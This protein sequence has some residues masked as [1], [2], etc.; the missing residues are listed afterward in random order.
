MEKTTASFIAYLN[1][2]TKVNHEFFYD[3]TDAEN[4]LREGFGLMKNGLISFFR[5]MLLLW[6]GLGLIRH[7][8]I[9]DRNPGVPGVMYKV[10]P[11]TEEKRKSLKNARELWIATVDGRGCG[12]GHQQPEKNRCTGE[13]TDG[14][15][16]AGRTEKAWSLSEHAARHQHE[17]DAVP[18]RQHCRS[19]CHHTAP[20]AVCVVLYIRG[21][22][23]GVI[24]RVLHFKNGVYIIN[25]DNCWQ[26]EYVQPSQI[27]GIVT[28]FYR[29]GVWH[30]VTEWRYRL[31][32]HLWADFFFIRRP[33]LYGR[34]KWK[35]L[36]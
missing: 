20:Q 28:R 19:S 3:I 8:F 29:H 23:Q 35:S 34:D 21:K 1:A 24:H 36:K 12:Y 9:Q 27:Y 6:D 7:Y 13:L 32:S 16:T 17:S 14:T 5:T 15:C 25:G 4:L 26:K 33:L 11:E 22:E 30:D 10:A 2:F 31:Y 18:E